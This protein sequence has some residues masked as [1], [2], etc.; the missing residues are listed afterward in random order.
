VP[1]NG[2]WWDNVSIATYEDFDPERGEFY[3][4]FNVFTRRDLTKRLNHIGWE[5]GRRPWWISNL[6][7]D[8][9]FCQV[10]WHIEN[11]FYTSNEDTVMTDQLTFGE[12]RA[13]CRI[14]RGIIHR[15]A[16]RGPQGRNEQVRRVGRNAVGMCL[17][18]DIGAYQWGAIKGFDQA[19][20]DILDNEVGFFK[21]ATF[22]PY[23]ENHI[24]STN[25]PG[26]QVSLYRGNGRVVA[27]LLS[28][29]RGDTDLEI[30]LNAKAILNGNK[31]TRVCDAETGQELRLRP[32]RKAGTIQLYEFKKYSIGIADRGLRLLVIE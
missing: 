16:T 8:W 32:N 25:T 26:V 23:W 11:D 10:A 13:L 19:I 17:L 15:L 14:K 27:V 24:L 29:L 3:H 18:H 4:K 7:V 2:T 22:I 30:E 5:V 6:H 9:S 31:V 20:L 12:F 1:V 28:S 21:D